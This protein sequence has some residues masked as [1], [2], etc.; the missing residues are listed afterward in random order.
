MG[1]TY[2]YLLEGI[3]WATV[4]KMMIDAPR[5]IIPKDGDE[6]RVLDT[7]E[8]IEKFVNSFNF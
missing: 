8:D 5:Y 7:D 3:G 6:N 1:W 4:Q 2:D